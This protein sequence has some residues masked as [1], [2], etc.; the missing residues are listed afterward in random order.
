MV[1]PIVGWEEG[2]EILSS[3]GGLGI[4]G[5]LVDQLPLGQRLNQT[6]IP[7]NLH[8][9]IAHRSDPFLGS[10][11]GF[12]R[13]RHRPRCG[14]AWTKRPPEDHPLVQWSARIRESNVALLQKYARLTPVTIGGH[15]YYTASFPAIVKLSNDGVGWFDLQ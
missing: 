7:E 6:R 15:P 11:W 8:P 13:Y 2:D 10:V 3:Q 9:D 12:R 1:R 4:I 5:A 14:N